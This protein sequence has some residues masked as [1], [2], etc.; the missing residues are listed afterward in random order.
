MTPQRM[1]AGGYGMATG[2]QTNMGEKE[3][4]ATKKDGWIRVVDGRPSKE[5][6]ATPVKNTIG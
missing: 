1:L 3:R 5:T 4:Q 6:E 2:Q